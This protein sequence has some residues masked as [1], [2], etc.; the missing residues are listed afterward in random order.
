MLEEDNSA[1]ISLVGGRSTVTRLGDI[2]FRQAAPWSRTTVALL[3]HLETEGFI[4]APRII[5]D[6]F[7][8]QG[9]EKLTFVPGDSP[10][11]YPWDD[12]ALPVIGAML[13]QL[14]MATASF[15]PPPDATWRRGLAEPLV[16]PAP[17]AIAIPAPGTSLRRTENP[18]R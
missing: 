4:Y 13:R 1:E 12:H 14:H 17:S 2:V 15:V 7:D 16:S 5:G 18:W 6:G 9:R 11:P 3:R 8:A 10:H